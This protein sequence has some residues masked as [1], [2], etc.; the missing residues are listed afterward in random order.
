[1]ER[2]PGNAE[3]ILNP[4]DAVATGQDGL[5]EVLEQ[6]VPPADEQTEDH[7]EDEDDDSEQSN[8]SQPEGLE[9][10]ANKKP[11]D[12]K[13]RPCMASSITRFPSRWIALK[14]CN[15]CSS[16]KIWMWR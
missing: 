14:T 10:I 7:D 4:P 15:S 16:S 13:S 6:L 2:L 11:R 12:A 1:M 9:P 8:A 5:D 3:D